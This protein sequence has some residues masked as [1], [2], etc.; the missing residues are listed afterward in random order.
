MSRGISRVEAEQLIVYGFLAPV[1]AE[2][3]L[4]GVAIQLQTLVEQKLG[5]IKE[6]DQASISE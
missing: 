5:Q 3:P 2:V 6:L 4:E 1:V